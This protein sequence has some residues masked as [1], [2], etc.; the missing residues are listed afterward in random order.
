MSTNPKTTP[1]VAEATPWR[2]SRAKMLLYE[3]IVGGIVT[4]DCV[5]EIVYGK[6]V[7]FQEYPFNNFKTNL[8]TLRN[9]INKNQAKADNDM[10]ALLHDMVILAPRDPSIKLWNGSAA[11]KQLKKDIDEGRNNGMTTREFWTSRAEYQEWPPKKFIK[12]VH[13]VISSRKQSNYWENRT[14]K[15]KNLMKKIADIVK[16]PDDDDDDEAN[17]YIF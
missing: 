3:D 2:F 12:H 7:E 15:K 6:R 14:T 11:Q 4:D 1:K 5:A 8:K 9:T 17:D 16:K 10:E 13:Q